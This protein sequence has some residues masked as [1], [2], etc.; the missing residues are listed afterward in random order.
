MK[1]KLLVLA[2][3]ATIT[4]GPMML[5]QADVKVGGFA[6]VEIGR[7][8]V[9]N[10]AGATTSKTTD[11][12][13]ASRG[14]FW[15]TA[16]E[17]LGGGMKGLAHFEFRVDT[18][19]NC[20][21]E[22]GGTTCSTAASAA[23]TREKYVGLKTNWGTVKLGSNKT[24]YKYYGGVNYDPLV[25]TLLEARGHGGMIGGVFGQNNFADNSLRYESPTWAGVSFEVTYGF[26]DAPTTASTFDDGDYSV[27][28]Q[29]KG[30]AGG[31]GLHFF[32]SRNVNQDNT[33]ADNETTWDKIGGQVKFMKDHAVSF[34]YETT[35]N[36]A[37][38]VDSSTYFIGYHG[39]FGSV[40]PVVQYGKTKDSTSTCTAGNNTNN[41]CTYIA[42]GAW[43]DLSKTFN[44]LAGYRKT[45]IDNGNETTVWSVGMRKGF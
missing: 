8:E 43:Y 14:R 44:L 41:D 21:L 17:D 34:Q 5:A 10:A 7:T 1:K 30:D 27:G 26:D 37:N 12:A 31:V 3:G 32:G 39:K 22:L 2:V 4:A 36:D 38:T 25:T 6:Q 13:D 19:G 28:V 40:R 20:G 15:I 16:D 9:D 29:W 11:S 24:A 33:A 45:D 42:V 35:E 23:N 18:T